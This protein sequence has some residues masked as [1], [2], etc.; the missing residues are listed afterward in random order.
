MAHFLKVHAHRPRSVP[1]AKVLAFAIFSTR[2]Q[3]E[4][5]R[6]TWEDYDEAG[7]RIWVRDMKHPG[8]KKGNHVLWG[9]AM[10]ALRI[11]NSMPRVAP[12]IFPFLNRCHYASFPCGPVLGIGLL[13]R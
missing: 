9:A 6:I 10:E 2:R 7:S 11:I 3:E 12:Q 5:T 13:S 1:M 8:D 4:I